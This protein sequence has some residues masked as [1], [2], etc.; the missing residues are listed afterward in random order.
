MLP[1]IP[2]YI[3]ITAGLGF[4]SA[5]LWNNSRY[6]EWV[7][8]KTGVTAMVAPFVAPFVALNLVKAM[9]IRSMIIT[10]NNRRQ[11]DT[12]QFNWEVK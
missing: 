6:G 2:I 9:I 12:S 5:K 10:K 11:L 8:V 7:R 4:L 1:I 3:G